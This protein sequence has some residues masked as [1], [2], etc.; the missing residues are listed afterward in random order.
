MSNQ[1]E[2]CADPD[3]LKC[4]D[5]RCPLLDSWI[6]QE[7]HRALKIAQDDRARKNRVV[8]AVNAAVNGIRPSVPMMKVD[9]VRQVWDKFKDR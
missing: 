8:D 7:M 1:C 6:V 4:L 9:I 5:I 3:Y 2:K